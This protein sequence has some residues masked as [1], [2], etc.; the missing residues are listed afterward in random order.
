MFFLVGIMPEPKPVILLTGPTASG[1]TALAVRIAEAFHGH[2]INADSMQL[3]RDLHILTAR[4]D[5]QDMARVTHCLY[6][7]VDGAERCSVAQ[8]RDLAQRDIEKTRSVGKLPIVVGGTGFYLNTLRDG[9]AEIPPIPD[10]IRAE[11]LA[12]YSTEGGTAFHARLGQVD[13]QTAARLGAGDRQ[14]LVRAWEVW[15]HTGV[16][17][18][19]WHNRQAHRPHATAGYRFV[20]IALLP[21][22]HALYERCNARFDQMLEC[23]ALAE[24]KQLMNRQLCHS[25]PIMKALGVPELSDYLGGNKTRAQARQLAQQ[26]TRHYAKRQ[27]TWIKNHFFSKNYPFAQFSESYSPKIFSFI[28]QNT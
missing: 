19:N 28:R 2:V 12:L 8:W 10:Q 6:G 14:R 25:L 22:R 4:P 11:G 18:S 23:G 13:P 21:E 16:N 9:I 5:E 24:V 17:L 15:R 3:Y 26:K 1:K 7:V 27:M 20:H